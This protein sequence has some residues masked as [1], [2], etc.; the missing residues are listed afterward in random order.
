MPEESDFAFHHS[1]FLMHRQNTHSSDHIDYLR[2]KEIRYTFSVCV[3]R[4]D[5][6]VAYID[7]LC[8]IY[9]H[10]SN[11][12][13]LSPFLKASSF[14]FSAS[15]ENIAMTILL[16]VDTAVEIWTQ[17]LSS[18]NIKLLESLVAMNKLSSK[19]HCVYQIK[20]TVESLLYGYTF[21]IA[22]TLTGCSFWNLMLMY[23]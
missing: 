6:Q 3:L 5:E 17:F 2:W 19:V 16:S 11:I 14:L 1:P 8:V 12:T 7:I 10:S 22:L 9:T 4:V 18:I 15:Y 13:S 23:E 21:S 20:G